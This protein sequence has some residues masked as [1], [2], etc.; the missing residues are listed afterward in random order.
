MAAGGGLIG[1]LIALWKFVIDRRKSGQD[2]HE[3]KARTRNTLAEARL[4]TD[5]YLDRIQTKHAKAVFD[6]LKLKEALGDKEERVKEL[7]KE[8][9]DLM[10]QN[11]SQ[12]KII[13]GLNERVG[14]LSE[15]VRRLK[16]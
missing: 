14:E 6:A 3:S 13:R 11:K 10:G 9:V 4:S 5:D 7:E 15:E 1:S 8:V 16:K 2:I 12:Q